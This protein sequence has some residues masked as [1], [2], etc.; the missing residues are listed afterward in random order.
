MRIGLFGREG[1]GNV[2]S[3][4]YNSHFQQSIHLPVKIPNFLY[5][6]L[7]SN[8]LKEISMGGEFSGINT[9]P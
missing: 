3:D 8:H 2:D 9:V 5:F 4:S 7:P 6:P 1:V